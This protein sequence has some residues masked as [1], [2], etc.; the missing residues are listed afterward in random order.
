MCVLLPENLFIEGVFFS[1]QGYLISVEFKKKKKTTKK[2]VWLL[3][4]PSETKTEKNQISR[5]EKNHKS[6]KELHFFNS[7]FKCNK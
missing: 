5:W 1:H 4:N 7:I 6:M 3:F 2:Q